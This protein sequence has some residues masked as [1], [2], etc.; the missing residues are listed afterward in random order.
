MRVGGPVI[1]QRRLAPDAAQMIRILPEII[2]RAVGEAGRRDAVLRAG[3]RQRLVI[4]RL[5]ARIGLEHLGAGGIVRVDP[6]HRPRRGGLLEP[7][8]GIGGGGLGQRDGRNGG[9]DEEGDH[10]QAHAV[11]FQ[12]Y[13]VILERD[14]SEWKDQFLLFSPST[15]PVRLARQFFPF[16]P[17]LSQDRS[18]R[19]RSRKGA[20]PPLLRAPASSARMEGVAVTA[21]HCGAAIV[22]QRRAELM[23]HEKLS[24]RG[25]IFSSSSTASSSCFAIS[26]R[27]CFSSEESECAPC[28]AGS[29]WSGRAG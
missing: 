28:V 29:A 3:D 8:I 27:A 26:S 15:F 17:S 10:G 23:V 13:I 9:G 7:D 6:R 18:T 5:V 21:Y 24:H 1:G 14:R 20:R 4:E 22:T 11:A 12:G 16:V 2:D 25:F 19:Q